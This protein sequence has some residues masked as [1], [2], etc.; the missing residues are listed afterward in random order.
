[1]GYAPFCCLNAE[2]QQGEQKNNKSKLII[3]YINLFT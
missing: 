3:F 1:M 2:K